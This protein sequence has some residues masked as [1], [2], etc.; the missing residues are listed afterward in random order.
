MAQSLRVTFKFVKTK[1]AF[2][3]VPDTTT[4]VLGVCR[5][6]DKASLHKAAKASKDSSKFIS[7]LE[8]LPQISGRADSVHSFLENPSLVPEYNNLV[9]L[10]VGTPKDL[11]AQKVLH[12]GGKIAHELRHQKLN[13]VAIS[14]DTLYNPASSNNASDAPRDFAGRTS[15]SGIPTREDFLEKLALGIALG[16]Y[17]FPKYKSKKE[18]S[19]PSLEVRFISS[20]LDGKKVAAILSRVE[21]LAKAAYLTRDLQTTPGGDLPPAEIAKRAQAAGREFGFSTTVWDEK[22]LKGEG[23]NGILTVGMGSANPPRF[24]IMEHNASQK[25][26]PLLVLV[27]KGISFDTGGICIK[28]AAGMEEMKMDM[29]GAA[30][31]IGAMAA[32]ADLEI[33]LRVVGLVASAENMP[34]GTAVRP[35]D[36]Y[37]AL[38]GT[39]VEVINTDA[40]GRLVLGDALSFAKT[41]KPDAC[42]DVATL[43][44]AVVIALGHVASGLMGNDAK[45][46]EQF[47]LASEKSGEKVW[48]LP[49]YPEYLEDIKSKI[50]DIKNVG[51]DRGA[52]SQKGGAFL[53]HF[54]GDSFPWIHLD[55]AGTADTPKGQGAHCP[56]DVGT[57]VPL[58]SL[59]EF[60]TQMAAG[61]K[62]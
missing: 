29:S 43:T 2:D 30:A 23:M 49:L 44:G 25:K 37:T 27:G 26:L 62:R 56:P 34:S 18:D 48:E 45:L 46:I 47:K 60:A 15:L 51:S 55:V 6:D 59:V 4:L 40:E 5:K 22:K 21:T 28:P 58:R 20:L 31:V 52:G 41:L 39:T 42:I 8:A 9:C 3:A 24:V 16:Q 11:T 19:P 50:A 36:I 35:G 17:S 54:V 14:I 38:G 53:Q 12:W 10:G 61:K 1:G 57:A 32:I 13:Q 7:R 33:P